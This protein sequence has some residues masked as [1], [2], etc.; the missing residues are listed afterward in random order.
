MSET[1]GTLE[2]DIAV[3]RAND[4]GA[5]KGRRRIN[6]LRQ[7]AER[8]SCARHGAAGHAFELRNVPDDGI[9]QA[10]LVLEVQK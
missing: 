7:Q 1:Q 2:R 10:R 8:N 9:V 5:S 3:T 6:E 4:V